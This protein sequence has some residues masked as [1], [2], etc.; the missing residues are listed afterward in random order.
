LKKKIERK[1]CE[2]CWSF[3]LLGLKI[4]KAF[5]DGERDEAVKEATIFHRQKL[6]E[7]S[8]PFEE[9]SDKTKRK[10]KTIIKSP[11]FFNYTSNFEFLL[12]NSIHS[13]TRVISAVPR[14]IQNSGGFSDFRR[15]E[16][17]KFVE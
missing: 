11:L 12:E 5:D 1:H 10:T 16:R 6:V 7:D 2:L 8:C 14:S 4:V 3:Q 17:T 13:V 9:L 15:I